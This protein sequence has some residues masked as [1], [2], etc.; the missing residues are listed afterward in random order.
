M[1]KAITEFQ[2]MILY[3]DMIEIDRKKH[4]YI[5]VNTVNANFKEKRQT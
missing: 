4:S 5:R 3:G 2:V 1:T